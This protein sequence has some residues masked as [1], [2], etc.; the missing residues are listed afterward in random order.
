MKKPSPTKFATALRAF[1]GQHLPLTRGLSP[2]NAVE[3]PRYIRAALAL[4]CK[5]PQL[6]D[7]RSRY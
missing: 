4:S 3:L 1:F 2:S 6:W 5:A 7:C